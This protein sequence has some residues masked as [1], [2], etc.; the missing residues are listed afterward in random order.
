MSSIPEDCDGMK[1]LWYHGCNEES[2]ATMLKEYHQ[3]LKTCYG[4]R[5]SAKIII[6]SGGK[7]FYSASSSHLNSQLPF[8]HPTVK[9]INALIE[10]QN[11]TWNNYGLFV[12]VLCSSM[13]FEAEALSDFTSHRVCAQVSSWVVE[14]VLD[15]L[16]ESEWGI[17][18]DL[19]DLNCMFSV[20]KT[21]LTSKST[22]KF[23]EEELVHLCMKVLQAFLMTVSSNGFGEIFVTEV[24]GGTLMDTE[25]FEGILYRAPELP[26]DEIKILNPELKNLRILMFTVSLTS[27]VPKSDII[28]LEKTKFE[29]F[30][31]QKLRVIIKRHGIDILASQKVIHP[32][33]RYHLEQDQIIVIDRLGTLQSKTL[34][35]LCHCVPLS[36]LALIEIDDHSPYI[37]HVTQVNHVVRSG[38]SYIHLCN[39]GDKYATLL[40]PGIMPSLASLFKELVE[41][42]RKAMQCAV[43][44]GKLVPGSGCL[45]S[46]TAHKLLAL[47]Q[48]NI[49][50][51]AKQ[52]DTSTVHVTEVVNLHIKTLM[53]TAVLLAGGQSALPLD[54][55]VD[56]RRHH[57]WQV[58][59]VTEFKQSNASG[60]DPDRYKITS[61]EDNIDADDRCACGMLSRKE[62]T[63]DGAQ[64]KCAKSMRIELLE[65]SDWKDIDF[66]IDK[67]WKGENVSYRSAECESS[68][69]LC[70]TIGDV[71][72]F[73]KC[74][75]TGRYCDH[76]DQSCVSLGFCKTF[77]LDCYS[78]KVNAYRL[79]FEGFMQL[80][81]VGVCVFDK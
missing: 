21:C 15:I 77:I 61:G 71:T 74:S 38:K 62:L 50:K 27:E 2:Y 44:D 69:I 60:S 6:N 7:S 68:S 72:R 11:N 39:S 46:W 47:A 30:L 4:P 43:M 10:A 1:R 37:G 45:E 81:Q 42:S 8:K 29:Y 76:E 51:L 9:F 49:R 25:I 53:Q 14:N 20:V 56:S 17:S 57:L 78:A 64:W 16:R 63:K 28:R 73:E 70:Q 12:G 32:I 13:L 31:L 35:Q 33:I 66:Q 22:F 40:L 55:Q 59:I 54:W 79:A 80:F 48:L 18:L 5:G 75:R 3:L 52:F 24:E 36:S 58:P 23:T 65:L 26:I 67:G 34:T 41:T 19:K